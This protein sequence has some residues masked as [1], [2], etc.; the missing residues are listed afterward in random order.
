MNVNVCVQSNGAESGSCSGRGRG[1]D[2]T[3]AMSCPGGDV[4]EMTLSEL[5][6][7]GGDISGAD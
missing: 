4:R 6:S 7:S 2:T 3:D 5:S 1:V